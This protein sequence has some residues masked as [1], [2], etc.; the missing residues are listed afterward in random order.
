[1]PTI[2]PPFEIETWISKLRFCLNS[3][4]LQK[5][6]IFFS[7]QSAQHFGHNW[8]ILKLV[9]LFWNVQAISRSNELVKLHLFEKNSTRVA[10]FLLHWNKNNS[11]STIFGIRFL[12]IINFKYIKTT[13][14]ISQQIIAKKIDNI[15]FEFTERRIYP[16]LINLTNNFKKGIK[17]SLFSL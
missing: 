16:I 6:L 5:L 8:L 1:M 14:Y 17:S 3:N 13:G 7:K 2:P 4:S 15:N 9:V 12:G 10:F 11:K